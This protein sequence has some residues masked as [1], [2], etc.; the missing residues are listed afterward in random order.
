MRGTDRSAPAAVRSSGARA[1]PCPGCADVATRSGYA[2]RVPIRYFDPR[3]PVASVLS[4]LPPSSAG[5]V[6][7]VRIGLLANGF[8]DSMAF[9][10]EVALALVRVIPQAAFVR[11]EKVS[12]PTPLTNDQVRVLTEDCGAVIAAYGH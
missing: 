3:P 10:D 12:P 9:L 8:P 1:A 11:I 5:P 4:T 2:H 6:E 7:T